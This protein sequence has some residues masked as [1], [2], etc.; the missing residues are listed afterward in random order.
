MRYTLAA[1]LML[2][3][4]S[5]MALAALGL[6]RLP[7]LFTRMQAAAKAGSLGASSILLGTAF[8][9]GE[10]EVTTR[11]LS[12]IAFLL[13]TA[14]LAAHMI[15]RAGYTLGVPLFETRIDELRERFGQGSK[16][17]GGTASFQPEKEPPPGKR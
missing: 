13:F 15:A 1:L 14:P 10:S 16:V 5:F 9:F 7:D 8:A 6:V 11:A 4:A 3:G 17:P 12:V 2:I